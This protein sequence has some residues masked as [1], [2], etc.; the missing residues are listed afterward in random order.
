MKH[1]YFAN[2]TTSTKTQDRHF[3]KYNNFLAIYQNLKNVEGT[4]TLDVYLKEDA[5]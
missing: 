3:L 5:P 2:K 1:F 4:L